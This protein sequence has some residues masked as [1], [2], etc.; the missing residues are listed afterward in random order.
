MEAINTL[1]QFPNWIFWRVEER[2]RKDGTAVKTKVLKN[3]HT[4][5]N[6]MS[7]KPET[8]GTY[9]QAKAAYRQYGGNGLG[10]VFTK[11]ANI[12]GVDL[13]NCI[14]KNGDLY[15]W[16]KD[17]VSRLGSYTEY[18]PSG[19][20]L[21]IFVFGRIPNNLKRD[22][23]G[24]E[25]YDHA[26]YFTIT[27]KHYPG[28][29]EVIEANQEGLTAVYEQYRRKHVKVVNSAVSRQNDIDVE[30]I[31]KALSFI[32]VQ[33]DY[34]DGWLRVCMAV[35]SILPDSEGVKL[36][37]DWSPGY[38][39]EVT[40]KF[41]S[42]KR[43]SGVGIGSLFALA[44]EHG[45]EHESKT[46]FDEG[47]MVSAVIAGEV[48][49][50]G[51]ISAVKWLPPEGGEWRAYYRVGD[52]AV[53]FHETQ[54]ESG[55]TKVT[56]E[57]DRGYLDGYWRGYHDAMSQ[58]RRAEWL[59]M[60]LVDSAVDLLGL[61]YREPGVDKSTGEILAAAY[62]VPFTNAAGDVSDIE[63]RE[64]DGG[65]GY[66][67]PDPSFC[68]VDPLGDH[69]SGRPIVLFDDSLKAVD[70]YLNLPG[71]Y[72]AVA[73]PH[74][75]IVGCEGLDSDDV[76]LIVEPG[77]RLREQGAGCLKGRCKYVEMGRPVNELV[78]DGVDFSWLV[79]Q[80]KKM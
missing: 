10:W 64:Y 52:S 69:E 20:G 26:R 28:T 50:S 66:E 17:I 79:R 4:G 42:F 18:S 30:Q 22:K 67:N 19:K 12:T 76:T 65:F 74:R 49:A 21:H 48:R 5:N 55:L 43:Q 16:A 56:T 25:M 44:M 1:K 2:Q 68:F 45:Y 29:P 13:D 35:H 36:I 57:Y 73:L 27:G 8:W 62:T 72:T 32:P 9:E 59:S 3:P 39:G 63:Y 47:D 31:R 77:N 7:N 51:Q 15:S 60:G 34:E 78:K 75:A 40:K 70:A 11:D 24:V 58:K 54:L 23:L 6:A 33:T 46:A 53:W 14:D 41:H 37:E 61:G 80:G 38:D 71:D